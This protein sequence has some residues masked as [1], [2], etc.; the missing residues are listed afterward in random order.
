M[1]YT[2]E[3]IVIHTHWGPN[4]SVTK[5][6]FNDTLLRLCGERPITHM[7]TNRFRG[8]GGRL[9]FQLF[10]SSCRKREPHPVATV[11]VHAMLVPFLWSWFFGIPEV[12]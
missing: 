12:P 10:Y 2:E 3:T 7:A 4:Q 8:A 9:E 5:D 6:T 11:F 1:D